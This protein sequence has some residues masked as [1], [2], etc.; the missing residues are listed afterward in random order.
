MRV[1][2]A[3]MVIFW[4]RSLQPSTIQLV[5]T[6]YMLVTLMMSCLDLYEFV[7]IELTNTTSMATKLASRLVDRF[8]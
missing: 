8:P 4:E 3:A 6:W 2:T 5:E 1:D 7:P